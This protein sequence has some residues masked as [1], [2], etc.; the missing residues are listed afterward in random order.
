MMSAR[1][2]LKENK[3]CAA[4][5]KRTERTRQKSSKEIGKFELEIIMKLNRMII[6][7]H[8]PSAPK[9]YLPDGK[10]CRYASD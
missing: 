3:A 4:L 8:F 2:K 1:V 7:N 6:E 9:R 10:V 5:I